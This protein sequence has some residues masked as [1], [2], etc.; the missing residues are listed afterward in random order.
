MTENRCAVT[1]KN[2]KALLSLQHFLF[3]LRF[4]TVENKAKRG[5]T[6]NRVFRLSKAA[7]TVFT[8]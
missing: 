8:L 4:K 2:G 3:T 7:R 6:E 5:T 1:P